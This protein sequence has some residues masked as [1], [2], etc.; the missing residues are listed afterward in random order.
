[1]HPGAAVWVSGTSLQ[2]HPLLTLP[3]RPMLHRQVWVHVADP[4]RWVAPGSLL[5]KEAE[6]SRGGTGCC[7]FCRVW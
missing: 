3:P 1:M 5:A 7:S 4:S 6:V 2:L